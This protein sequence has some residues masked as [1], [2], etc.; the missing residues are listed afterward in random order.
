VD[1][2]RSTLEVAGA[3]KVLGEH[4]G[5]VDSFWGTMQVTGDVPNRLRVEFD[6]TTLRLNRAIVEEF[7]KSDAFLDVGRYPRAVFDASE[8]RLGPGAGDGEV[9]G[10][11]TLH[12][13]TR[14]FRFPMRSSAN[15]A[16]RQLQANVL[17]PRKAFEIRPAKRTWDFFISPDFRIALDL[18]LVTG[19]GTCPAAP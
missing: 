4:V 12:G 8:V 17:L 18:R 5:S 7:V 11:L 2:Q 13:H 14:T 16:E 9:V 6:L 15:G 1:R 10:E 3:D 19:A